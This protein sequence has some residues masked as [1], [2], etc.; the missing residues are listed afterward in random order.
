[1]IPAISHT[2]LDSKPPT[3]IIYKTYQ[4]KLRIINYP[5]LLISKKKD[6]C[7]TVFF[8]LRLSKNQ[9]ESEAVKFVGK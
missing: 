1:M 4:K 6:D 7:I 8:Y 3:V 9:S 5:E 2:G